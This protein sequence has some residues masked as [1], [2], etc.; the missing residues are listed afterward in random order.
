M[1]LADQ[2]KFLKAKLRQL[3]SAEEI[4]IDTSSARNNRRRRSSVRPDANHGIPIGNST[5]KKKRK[6]SVSHGGSKSRRSS[7]RSSGNNS[8]RR[9]SKCSSIS[10][11]NKK[12]FSAKI[13]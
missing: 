9:G 12:N 6:N 2:K 4:E 3:G 8:S 10:S 5:G 13:K 11:N 1:S 7:G